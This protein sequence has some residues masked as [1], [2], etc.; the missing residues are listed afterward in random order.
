VRQT[1]KSIQLKKNTTPL[2][3]RIK[4]VNKRKQNVKNRWVDLECNKEY[5]KVIRKRGGERKCCATN[6]R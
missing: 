4:G 5:G 2:A 3:L 6:L 1:P